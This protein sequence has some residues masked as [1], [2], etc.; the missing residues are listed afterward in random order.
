MPPNGKISADPIASDTTGLYMAGIQGGGNVRVPPGLF[1]TGDVLASNNLSDLDDE[2]A[3]RNNLGIPVYASKAIIPANSVSATVSAFQ[4]YGDATAGDLGKA[5]YKEV[6]VEPSHSGKVQT[7]DGRWWEI[8]EAVISPQMLNVISDA[9]ASDQTVKMQAWL[10]TCDA[11]DR[12]MIAPAPLH[13][14]ITDTLTFPTAR[15]IDIQNIAIAYHGVKDRKVLYV[16][17]GSVRV[18]RFGNIFGNTVDWTSDDY[19][20]IYFQDLAGCEVHLNLTRRFTVGYGLFGN[21]STGCAY[22]RIYP[23]QI[24]DCKYNER[25]KS[26]TAGGFVNENVFYAGNYG[27]TSAAAALGVSYGTHV[28]AAPGGYN[29]HNNNRWIAPNYE[30]GGAA[31][32]NRVPFFFD[33]AG[34][35]NTCQ[36]ARAEAC[37]GPLVICNGSN[38]TNNEIG[39]NFASTAIS[40]QL[41]AV[42]EVN[43]ANSNRL[44]GRVG[45]EARRTFDNLHRLLSSNSAAD[46]PYVRGDVFLMESTSGAAK[47]STTVA[48]RV[49]SN[50]LGLELGAAGAVMVAVD[51]SKIKLW[52]V[53][54]AYAGSVI[55]SIVAVAWDATGARLTGDATDPLGDEKYI[56]NVSG[57]WAATANFGGGYTAASFSGGLFSV[58]PEVQTMWIGLA[59]ATVQSF[60][61]TGYWT[62]ET[63]DNTVGIQSVST[64]VPLDDDGAVP[65]ASANPATAGTHGYYSKGHVVYNTGAAS[66]QPMGWQCTTAGWLAGPWVAGAVLTRI[67]RIQTNDSGKMYQLMTAGTCAGAGGPTGTGSGIADNTCIWNYVGVQAVFTAL[68]NVP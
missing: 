18:M 15:D 67:G 39:F 28:T 46:G 47:R 4:V 33:G 63:L 38:V 50:A 3:A 24:R 36:N 8:A 37:Y 12:P 21:A 48:N 17:G 35:N 61:L 5:L 16:P 52:R 42:Q 9:A 29:G 22:N 31:G 65:L 23:G 26:L 1:G 62:V 25:L 64:W 55:G 54:P 14:R 2:S 19:V 44:V 27:N 57:G 51:T 49:L 10:D 7:P 34:G 6:G 30:M 66:G 59:S 56:K 60:D 13:V 68:A 53:S 32:V 43:G 45:G 20:G 11:L 41:N 58:R 40:G